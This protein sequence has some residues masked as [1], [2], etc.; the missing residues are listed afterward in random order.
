MGCTSLHNV[1]F[2]AMRAYTRDLSLCLS[3]PLS[4]S[5]SRSLCLSFPPPSLPAPSLPT[6]SYPFARKLPLSPFI[7][8]SPPWKARD[9]RPTLALLV[10]HQLLD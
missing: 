2:I 4:L 6:P 5:F 9:H 7:S 3:R 10:G 1:V 8:L